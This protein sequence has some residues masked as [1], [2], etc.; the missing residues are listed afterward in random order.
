MALKIAFFISVVYKRV[1]KVFHKFYGV[2][3]TPIVF[4][5]MSKIRKLALLNVV[6]WT[7]FAVLAFG[8]SMLIDVGKKCFG[9]FYEIQIL[10]LQK[11]LERI[12]GIGAGTAVADKDMAGES[13]EIRDTTPSPDMISSLVEDLVPRIIERVKDKILSPKRISDGAIDEDIVV[14]DARDRDDDLYADPY[15]EGEEEDMGSASGRGVPGPLVQDVLHDKEIDIAREGEGAGNLQVAVDRGR[16][17]HAGIP[18]RELRD[19]GRICFPV[20][21]SALYGVDHE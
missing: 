7:L 9:G 14:V 13:G 16:Q 20:L 11:A 12:A 18:C 8:S 21:G 1:Y 15:S 5:K 6:V 10:P 3:M 17:R 19:E 2:Q 4:K